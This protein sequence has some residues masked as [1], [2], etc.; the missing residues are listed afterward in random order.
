MPEMNKNILVWID[1]ETTGLNTSKCKLLEVG[2]IV[3]DK[4]LN[5]LESQTHVIHYPAS[6]FPD[7]LAA[8]SMEQIAYEMHKEN[9]LLD[10]VSNWDTSTTVDLAETQI[11]SMID[12]HAN[13][14]TEPLPAGGGSNFGGYDKAVLRRFMPRLV[15]RLHHRSMDTTTLKV[16][17]DLWGLQPSLVN[18]KVVRSHRALDD[19]RQDIALAGSM[20][21][22]L[23]RA[24]TLTGVANDSN[25]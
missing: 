22:I 6:C 25:P 18:A 19:I 5:E 8:G 2:V 20:M 10:E 14:I 1:T 21:D 7:W 24:Q 4:D 23:T 16:A 13:P 3:T 15:N 9:G 12:R 17:A 11:I